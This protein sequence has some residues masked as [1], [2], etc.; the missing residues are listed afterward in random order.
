MNYTL[1]SNLEG[2]YFFFSP[3]ETEATCNPVEF[4]SNQSWALLF[5]YPL[6]KT[7]EIGDGVHGG[8]YVLMH[9]GKTRLF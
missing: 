4:G 2:V 5:P 9:A 1:S 7:L 8:S 3:Q 6:L